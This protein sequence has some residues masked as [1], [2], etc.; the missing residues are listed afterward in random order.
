MLLL[1]TYYLQYD[2]VYQE[3]TMIKLY[4]KVCGKEYSVKPYRKLIS[5]TCSKSCSA[6]STYK[7]NLKNINYSHMIGNQYRK[8]LTPPKP[9][10]K[11]HIPWNKGIKGLHHSPTTEFK[12]GQRG[13]CWMPIGTITVRKDRS[14]TMRNMEKIGEPNIWKPHTVRVWKEKNGDVPKGCILHHIDFNSLNDVI[15]NIVPLTRKAHFEIHSIGKLG[16]DA[17]QKRC[18]GSI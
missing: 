15:E 4:C 17:I 1:L 8:G 10:K 12:K 13:T 5:K 11:G 14:G 9:F 7:N 6:K 3:V 18:H 2:N 16:R